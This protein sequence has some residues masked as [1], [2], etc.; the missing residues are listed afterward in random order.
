MAICDNRKENPLL[1]YIGRL[2]KSAVPIGR[3]P[4]TKN[5]AKIGL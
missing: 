5:R 1:K 2:T 3:G 4:N